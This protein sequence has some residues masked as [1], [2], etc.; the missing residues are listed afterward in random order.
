MGILNGQGTAAQFH[1]PYPTAVG[2]NGLIYVADNHRIR[3]INSTGYVSTLA[4]RTTSYYSDGY[5][6]S[7]GFY[8]PKGLGIGVNGSV[9]VADSKNNFIRSI[10]SDSYVR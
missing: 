4:G 5:S 8:G 7:A 10:T 1:S 3:V 2:L 9:I 6:L